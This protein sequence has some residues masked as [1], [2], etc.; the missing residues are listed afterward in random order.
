MGPGGPGRASAASFIRYWFAVRSSF[1]SLR[2]G[3]GGGRQLRERVG[4]GFPAGGEWGVREWATGGGS[5][6]SG[7]GE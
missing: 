3:R 7:G 2:H 4:R 5:I 6:V 1:T